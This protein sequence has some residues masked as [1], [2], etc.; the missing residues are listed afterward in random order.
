MNTE[1]K[2]GT[3]VLFRTGFGH[4]D[5]KVARVTRIEKTKAPWLK[6]GREVKSVMSNEHYVLDLDCGNWCYCHQVDCVLD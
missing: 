5:T 2:I 6:Y 1:I 3:C 4:G